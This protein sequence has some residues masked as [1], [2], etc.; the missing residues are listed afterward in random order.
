VG[1]NPCRG[2][3]PGGGD[4]RSGSAN[5]ILEGSTELERAASPNRASDPA[6]D[7]LEDLPVACDRA[8]RSEGSEL[9]ED[10]T[11][12]ESVRV[13]S[14]FGL[15]SVGDDNTSATNDEDPGVCFNGRGTMS[16][17]E[18]RTDDIAEL[19]LLKAGVKGGSG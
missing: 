19:T 11:A 17:I 14:A 4:N 9:P 8:E 13:D 5:F 10:R 18:D 7:E 15:A 1:V 2:G 6:I 12:G 3:N 16:E